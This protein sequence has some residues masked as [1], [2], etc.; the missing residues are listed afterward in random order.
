MRLYLSGKITGNDNYRKDFAE[1]RARLENAGYDVCDPTDLGFPEDIP[2]EDAMRH[3]IREMLGCDGVA[4]LPSWEESGGA[5]IEAR[6]ARDLGMPTRPLSR[7]L[8]GRSGVRRTGF[9]TE[10]PD[11]GHG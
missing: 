8:G 3:D 11:P 5:R 1:G 2:W 6:L 4:L 10:L 7:W 9:G